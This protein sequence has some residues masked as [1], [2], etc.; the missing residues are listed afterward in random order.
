MQ[1][2]GPG[3]VFLDPA[4]SFGVCFMNTAATGWCAARHVLN[5]NGPGGPVE[6][7]PL[8]G[9]GP[10]RSLTCSGQGGLDAAC[11]CLR[12]LWSL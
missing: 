12:E 2:E 9:T 1:G 6:L 7:T 11:A 4:L 10:E 3:R 8:A 5:Q